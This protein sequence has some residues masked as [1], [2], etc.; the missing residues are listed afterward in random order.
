MVNYAITIKGVFLIM[1][2]SEHEGDGHSLTASILCLFYDQV[3]NR[4]S[5][6]FLS[7]KE[8]TLSSLIYQD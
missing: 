3:A 1:L 2:T 8:V 4:I 7:Q 5:L 6:D